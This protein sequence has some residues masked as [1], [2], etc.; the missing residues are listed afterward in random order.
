MSLDYVSKLAP[1]VFS[2]DYATARQKFI[3]AAPDS[4]EIKC[5]ATGPSGEPLYTGVAYYGEVDA[6][7]LLVLISATHG[8]EG[9]C[10]SAAQISFLQENLH[11]NLPSSTAVLII[12][13]LNSY[14]FAWDRRVTF[15]GCDLNRNFIDF[16]KPLPVNTGY[17]ELSDAI[18]PRELSEDALIAGSAT[19]ERYKQEKGDIAFT[20]AFC[21]G[22]YSHPKGL[23]HGGDKPTE[24]RR[25]LERIMEAHNPSA[26][27]NVI[28]IDYHSGLGPYGYGELQT[29]QATG[30]DGYE[31][32]RDVF[33]DSVTSAALGTSAA[34]VLHGTQAEFWE[35]L[36]G[37][38]HIYVCLE[39]GTYSNDV[40]F[41]VLRK[42]HWLFEHSPDD[43]NSDL[44]K[45]IRLA[46]KNAF[47][48]QCDNWK[49]MVVTRAHQ[50][51]Q[52]ALAALTG[53]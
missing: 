47:Y 33:G 4:E 17:A 40:V 39:Y 52:Q 15:E 13:A 9:Y 49:E 1:L 36:F 46:T 11:R 31:R 22:Q 29:E 32:A 45:K 2:D 6:P 7:N 26:R 51:H 48:A 53:K 34:V 3:A 37:D 42:D 43:A 24:A 44:G 21:G 20:T 10:G 8:P 16:S 28:V 35:R 25:T 14:G 41:N 19:L 27:K 18:V 30:I 12:H 5:S 50:V 23:F 38:K